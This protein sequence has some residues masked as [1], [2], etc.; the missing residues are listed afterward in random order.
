MTFRPAAVRPMA[1][2]ALVILAAASLLAGCGGSDACTCEWEGPVRFEL[3]TA[4][5]TA[6]ALFVDAALEWQP[7]CEST[8]RESRTYRI[9]PTTGAATVATSRPTEP[10][11]PL[12]VGQPTLEVPFDALGTTLRLDRTAEGS[13]AADDLLVGAVVRTSDGGT[14]AEI[15]VDVKRR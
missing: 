6:D 14:T 1:V 12:A 11:L 3:T 8:E 9:D 4:V 2:G 13:V 15:R 7:C 5:A 10:V